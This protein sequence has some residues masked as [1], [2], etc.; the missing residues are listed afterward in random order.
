MT[1]WGEYK[2]PCPKCGGTIEY[3]F[4]S[5]LD[6]CRENDSF[7][8]QCRKCRKIFT[9][10]ER[11]E[12]G[13]KEKSSHLRTI[14]NLEVISPLPCDERIEQVALLYAKKIILEKTLQEGRRPTQSE[15]ALEAALLAAELGCS[16]CEAHAFLNEVYNYQ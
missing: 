2:T 11:R 15:L 3:W 5:S 12:I 1:E 10:E 13:R 6:N 7:G 9:S 16:N 8:A 4:F 14:A